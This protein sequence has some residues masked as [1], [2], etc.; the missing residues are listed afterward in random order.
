MICFVNIVDTSNFMLHHNSNNLTE[1]QKTRQ[2]KAT[3]I[4]EI[5]M[6]IEALN[7]KVNELHSQLSTLIAI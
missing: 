7:Q 5:N 2:N 1:S 3:E 4:D 6:K